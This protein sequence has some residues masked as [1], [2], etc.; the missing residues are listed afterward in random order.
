MKTMMATSLFLQFS[1]DDIMRKYG[2]GW[3]VAAFLG[4]SLI[5]GTIFFAIIFTLGAWVHQRRSRRRQDWGARFG[6]KLLDTKDKRRRGLGYTDSDIGMAVLRE[7]PYVG[8]FQMNHAMA[9]HILEGYLDQLPTRVFESRYI[10]GSGKHSVEHHFSV[11]AFD[12]DRI[13]PY[14][15]L[16]RHAWRDGLSRDDIKTGKKEIDDNFY[17]YADDWQLLSHLPPDIERILLKSRLYDFV[18][19]GDKLVVTATGRLKDEG[20]NRLLADSRRLANWAASLN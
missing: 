7:Y 9:M 4:Y 6:L 5:A 14:T 8:I 19:A 11:V 10:T 13:K 3:A 2:E 15:A 16:R 18:L 17:I 20:Y 1:P 12:F